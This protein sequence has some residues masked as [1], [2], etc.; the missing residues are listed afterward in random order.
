MV[1]ISNVYN[2]FFLI[3]WCVL[4]FIF[5]SIFI[6]NFYFLVC[7][8]CKRNIQISPINIR[9]NIENNIDEEM[10]YDINV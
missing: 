8:D 10:K 5:L 2:I 1:K 9:N 7:Y 3:I 4:L 6:Y